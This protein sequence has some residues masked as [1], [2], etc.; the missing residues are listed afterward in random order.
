VTAGLESF[1]PIL[2]PDQAARM[3]QISRSTLYQHVSMGRYRS[4]VRRG[5]PLR[6]HRDLLALEFFGRR[7]A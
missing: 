1:P 3:L 6:L 2:T 5:K 4:A 7:R